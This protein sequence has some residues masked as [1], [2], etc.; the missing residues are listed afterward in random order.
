MSEGYLYVLVSLLGYSLLGISHKLADVKQC[1]P[2]A[3]TLLLFFW[4]GL[5]TTGYVFAAGG[6]EE[7]PVKVVLIALV[8]GIFSSLAILTFQAGLRYGKI[9]TSWLIM[10]LSMAVPAVLSI[11]IYGEPVGLVKV[12]SV[13]LIF[14]SMFLLWQDKKV[15]APDS[16]SGPDASL[17]PGSVL[18]RGRSRTVRWMSLMLAAFLLNGLGAFGL[19]VLVGLE[20]GELK[21]PYIAFWYWSGFIL[22][23]ATYFR[24]GSLPLTREFCIGALMATCSVVGTLGLAASLDSGLPG[25]IIYPVSVGGG[26]F[27]VVLAGVFLF[28]EKV[29]RSGI[30]GILI[31]VGAIVT[32]ALAG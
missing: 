10:N 21:M 32:L 26:L 27:L 2:R 25:F 15:E 6:Y 1:G 11:L 9:A 5:L 16:T 3:I 8:F 14:L 31:G 23:A 7:F 19:R 22:M 29:S 4:G 17:S 30:L 20:L 24:S 12:A 18:P 13:A 28:G